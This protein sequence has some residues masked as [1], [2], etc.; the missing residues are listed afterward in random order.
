MECL[1]A[2]TQSMC[3]V[4]IKRT[5]E[6]LNHQHSSQTL[7]AGFLGPSHSFTSGFVIADSMYFLLP[8]SLNPE[9]RKARHWCWSQHSCS[10]SPFL[11]SLPIYQGPDAWLFLLISHHVFSLFWLQIRPKDR[12]VFDMLHA[13][14]R[15]LEKSYLKKISWLTGHSLVAQSNFNVKS[16][17]SPPLSSC[18]PSAVISNLF[19]G[20]DGYLGQVR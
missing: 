13:T 20:K 3:H 14:G 5:L 6:V 1:L 19:S 15:N 18:I 7:F 12:P 4:R 16:W 8:C 9:R 2:S 17:V 11:P 10:L